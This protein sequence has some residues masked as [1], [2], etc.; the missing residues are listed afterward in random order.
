MLRPR[1]NGTAALGN[2]YLRGFQGKRSVWKIMNLLGAQGSE[3]NFQ[4]YTTYSQQTLDEKYDYA[5]LLHYSRRAFSRNSL[6]T[7]EPK[8][9]VGNFIIGQRLGFSP[10]DIRKINKLYNCTK[11]L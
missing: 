11:Y 1:K 4:K 2:H 8:N 7:I 3:N 10:T 6:P 5:S 9:F